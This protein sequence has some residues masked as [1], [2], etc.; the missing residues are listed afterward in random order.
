PAGGGVITP[1]VD[2]R[3]GM[4]CRHKLITPGLQEWVDLHEQPV[5][6][7]WRKPCKS[8]VDVAF[9]A[10]FDHEQLLTQRARRRPHVARIERRNGIARIDE[11]SERFGF[12]K[13]LVQ[14]LELL[15]FE[16]FP[17]GGNGGY[18]SARLV[19]TGNETELDRVTAG[20]ERDGNRRG[21]RLA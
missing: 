7:F 20:V 17:Q 6:F 9:A 5:H 10:C 3:Y 19:E 18:V 13:Q 15:G 8:C 2:R 16:H 11:E 12:G 4:A 21:R 14:Q 1:T